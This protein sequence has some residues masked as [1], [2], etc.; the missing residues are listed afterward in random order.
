MT[1]TR[2]AVALLAGTIGAGVLTGFEL[3]ASAQQPTPPRG[4]ATLANIATAS[5]DDVR[6]V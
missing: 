1:F 6:A 3:R 4:P 2:I 5:S